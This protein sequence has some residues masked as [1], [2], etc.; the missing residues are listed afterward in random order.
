MQ[1]FSG[2]S[3]FLT[4][5]GVRNVQF[6]SNSLCIFPIEVVHRQRHPKLLR[7]PP[8]GLLQNVILAGPLSGLHQLLGEK[9][10]FA[11]LPAEKIKAEVPGNSQNPCL[12]LISLV[13]FL[14]LQET[15]EHGLLSYVFGIV[16]IP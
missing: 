4:C 9:Y 8:D 10:L 14:Y 12:K 5:P 1:L 16:H 2:L 3:Y 6:L 13:E 11:F 15:F 7:Q